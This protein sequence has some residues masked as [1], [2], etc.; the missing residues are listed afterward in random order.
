MANYQGI[1]VV[2]IG[3]G[4]TGLSCIDFFMRRGIIPR[5]I[6][7][8]LNP[9]N[10]HK[11]PKNIQCHL[12]GINNQWLFNSD[13]IITSPGVPL[14]HPSL[15]DAAKDG[16][17]IIGDIEL[18]CRETQT[19]IIAITGSNGKSTVTA[20]VSSIAKSAGIIVGTGGNIGFP[21]LS[22]LQNSVQLYILELSSFQLETTKTLQATVAMIL[23]IT[24]DHMDRYP[25]GIQQYSSAKMRIYTHAKNCIFNADDRMTIPVYNNHT[26]YQSFGLNNGDYQLTYHKDNIWLQAKGEIFLNTNKMQIFGQ[27]N[28]INALAALAV[29]DAINIPRS[30]SKLELTKF[31]GLEHRFQLVY[32]NKGVRW[33]ND[34]KSTN[35][36]STI[37]ALKSAYYT[38]ILWLLLGGDGKSADFTALRKF[39]QKP[40]IRLY[41]FGKDSNFIATLHPEITVK[42]K[43]M[44]EAILQISIQ[45]QHGDLVLLT[46]ACSSLD[47]FTSFKQRGDLFSKLAREVG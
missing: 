9:P 36:G 7:T 28:L 31:R 15:I 26:Y 18:F 25:Q 2:I 8:R 27:H 44:S 17:E 35:I 39:L 3:L 29:A 37:A 16:I 38:G 21:V 41:C 46:P 45:V 34:S 43:T 24:E 20:W 33:V 40:N 23:N 32:Q 13:L 1:K 30:I 42:T 4:L 10:V 19:P 47:Q 11:L 5:V 14:T 6:D 22:L 12:G